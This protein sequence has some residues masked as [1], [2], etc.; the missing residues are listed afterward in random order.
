M[1]KVSI[2]LIGFKLSTF[3]VSVISFHISFVCIV[4]HICQLFSGIH[5]WDQAA[6]QAATRTQSQSEVR[7]LSSKHSDFIINSKWD[8]MG[9][10][11]HL[12]VSIMGGVIDKFHGASNYAN[13]SSPLVTQTLVCRAKS[14]G[15]I[16]DL[17]TLISQNKPHLHCSKED[18]ATHVVVGVFYGAEVYCVLSNDLDDDEELRDKILHKFTTEWKNSLEQSQDLIQFQEKFDKKEKQQLIQIKCRIYSDLPAESVRED[19]NV[20][21]A[22]KRCLILIDQVQNSGLVPIAVLL[23]PLDVIMGPTLQMKC[24]D[25]DADL[26]SR[27]YRVI[28]KLNRIR[29][30]VDV[31]LSEVKLVHRPRLR[32]FADAIVKYQEVFKKNLKDAVVEARKS[33]DMEQLEKIVQVSEN[34]LLF[35]PSRLKRWLYYEEAEI[36]MTEKFVN[37]TERINFVADADVNFDPKPVQDKKYALLLCVPSLNEM[38]VTFI[39]NMENWVGKNNSM[40]NMKLDDEDDDYSQDGDTSEDEEEKD[41]ISFQHVEFRRRILQWKLKELTDHI[42]RNKGIENRI[43]FLLTNDRYQE[44]LPCYLLCDYTDDDENPSR[45]LWFQLPKPPTNLRISPE[46]TSKT[47]K[48][49][50]PSGSVSIEWDQP[51]DQDQMKSYPYYYVLEFRPKGSTDYWER[52]KTEDGQLQATICKG[53]CNYLQLNLKLL[54]I[55]YI[56]YMII[57]TIYSSIHLSII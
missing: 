32:R 15:D 45:T 37:G 44:T 47:K 40:V 21:D 36:E 8:L 12:Q 19:T 31:L 55:F 38:K 26:V 20:F 27:C 57:F 13:D 49:K 54:I 53:K 50:T 4:N 43:Q 3:L 35:R 52:K 51:D 34:H 6:L 1:S 2:I 25:I 29:F 17:E 42:R 33:N 28:E 11:K 30:K 14:R 23:C 41:G 56:Y 46:A 22:Y 10:D 16:L 5:V 9:L 39:D 18:E 48:A 24:Y 7:L